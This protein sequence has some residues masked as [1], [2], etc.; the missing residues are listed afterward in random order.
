MG[1]YDTSGYGHR[2]RLLDSGVYEISWWYDK[3]YSDSRLRYPRRLSRI[4]DEA[5][6]RRFCRKWGLE[7]PGQSADNQR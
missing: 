2:C 7:M 3:Y 6:A 5:G 4:T 1:R